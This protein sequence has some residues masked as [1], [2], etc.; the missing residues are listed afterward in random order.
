[1]G[2]LD[3]LLMKAGT[4]FSNGL[5][6]LRFLANPLTSAIQGLDYINNGGTAHLKLFDSGNVVYEQDIP[7]NSSSSYLIISLGLIG[8]GGILSNNI[9]DEVNWENNAN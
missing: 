9:T 8:L 3:T 5:F 2:L 1:M 7:A 4:Q 6:Q